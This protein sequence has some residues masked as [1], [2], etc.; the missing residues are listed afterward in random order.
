MFLPFATE[1]N[2]K[3]NF[4]PHTV[5][6]RINDEG[7]FQSLFEYASMVAELVDME[8]VNV[9]TMDWAQA[10]RHDGQDGSADYEPFRSPGSGVY[11]CR[12]AENHGKL[13]RV[14]PPF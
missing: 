2:G 4:L 1:I 7:R 13:C 3:G 14:M 6:S 5:E 8:V 10:R 12:E 9:P 11:R